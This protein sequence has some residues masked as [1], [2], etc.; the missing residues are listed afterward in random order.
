MEVSG[1]L[2]S[3]GSGAWTCITAKHGYMTKQK[4]TATLQS[5]LAPI[6]YWYIEHK[7][8]LINSFIMAH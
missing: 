5:H 4:L 3:H 1:K 6:Y 7:I 2:V 8:T